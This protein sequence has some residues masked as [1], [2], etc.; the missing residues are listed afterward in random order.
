MHVQVLTDA[1]V[2]VISTSTHALASFTSTRAPASSRK[3]HAP[4][5]SRKTHTHLP[6]PGKQSSAVAEV[7][8]QLDIGADV[9]VDGDENGIVLRRRH[10]R[11]GAADNALWW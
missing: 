4:A 2:P 8:L 6:V 9:P 1:H 10:G 11:A 3:K 5:S 7:Q